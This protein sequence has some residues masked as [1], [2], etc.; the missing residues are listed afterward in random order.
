MIRLT[1][2]F[3]AVVAAAALTASPAAAAIKFETPSVVDPIHPFGEPSV[4]VDGFGRTFASG[5]TGTGTQRSVWLSS[6]DGGHT[7]RVITPGPPPSAVQGIQDPPGGG[8]TD[9]AFDSHDKQYFIDLYALSCDRTSTTTDAGATVFQSIF[10]AGCGG[11]AGSDRPWLAV[12]D[13]PPGTANQSAYTGPRPLI[14]SESN[15]LNTGAQWVMSNSSVDPQPGGPGLNFV[16]AEQDGPGNVTQYSPFG[17]DGYP[18][19]DQVTGKVFQAAGRQASANSPWSLLLN[20]GT[21]NASGSL[22]FLDAPAIP[23]TGSDTSKLIHI[24]DNL[25]GDPDTLFVVLS[26]DQARNLYVTWAVD[27]PA[28]HTHPAQRQVYVSAASAASGWTRWTPPALASDGSTTTGDAANVFPWIQGGAPGRADAVWYGS[29]KLVDASSQSGQA[30]NVFM[31]AFVFPTDASGGI[32]GAAPTRTLVKV[33]PHPAHYNDICLLGS[34]C[35]TSQGN[36]NLADFFQIKTDTTGA[37]EIIYDDTSNG[38]VQ[39]GFTPANQQAVDHAG[40]AMVTLA[41]QSSGPGLFGGDVSG[42]SSAPAR[43]QLD[44][45]GDARFPVLGGT[46]VAGLDI[47]RTGLSLS[48]GTLK[49]TMQVADLAHPSQTAARIGGTQL[50]QYVLRW[51]MG[52]TLYYAA[53]STTAS[54]SRSFYAGR[55][56]SVDLCSVSAC[57]PHVIT[58]PEPGFAGASSETGSVS[59]PRSPS[60][61]SPCTLT[62]NVKA[63]DVGGPS[64]STLLEEVGGYAFAASHQQGVTTNAQAQADNVPLEVDGDC[65][66][67]F[68]GNA[69]AGPLPASAIRRAAKPPIKLTVRPRIT[70]VGCRRFTFHA[71]ARQRG[72]MRALRGAKITFAGRHARTGRRGNAV[73]TA[74]LR[75]ARGFRATAR[76]RG[77]KDG[78]VKVSARPTGDDR[79]RFT[80]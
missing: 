31:S 71:T 51:Q 40:A 45:A 59:C 41:R 67:N 34:D 5:P 25:P 64:R 60:A 20:I 62:I 49:A 38:L 21:P 72:R 47:L 79:P 80:G 13:P 50:L 26:M 23:G 39:P 37:A 42:P 24:A 63:R 77:F 35:I 68:T 9:I 10:P 27:D 29:D 17:A 44:A 76:K 43:G 3:A 61:S 78:H 55:S 33:S 4:G 36:R 6:A 32:T 15:N 1:G 8:D 48:G 69:T 66:F 70:T 74:C 16:N 18:A 52:N 53:M 56:Q 75:R 73:I 22:K 46:N 11:L 30:W 19:I 65:C 7:F 14:Y 58:Y 28:P 12:Y 2:M 57:D 54:G